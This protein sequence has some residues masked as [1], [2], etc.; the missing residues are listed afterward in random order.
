M[1]IQTHDL[2]EKQKSSRSFVRSGSSSSSG[3]LSAPNTNTSSTTPSPTATSTANERDAELDGEDDDGEG[4]PKTPLPPSSTGKKRRRRKAN[5]IDRKF[6]CS[7]PGCAK[8]YGSEGSLT[9]HQRLKHRVDLANSSNQTG[10]FFLPLHRPRNATTGAPTTNHNMYRQGPGMSRTV[11]IRPALDGMMIA[12]FDVSVA[13]AVAASGSTPAPSVSGPISTP[14]TSTSVASSLHIDNVSTEFVLA[15]VDAHSQARQKLRVRSNSMPISSSDL[16]KVEHPPFPNRSKGS[17]M[18]PRPQSTRRTRVTTT[19][20]PRTTTAAMASAKLMKQRSKSESLTEIS[21][22][23]V[24]IGTSQPHQLMRLSFLDRV[25]SDSSP[26]SYASE[27]LDTKGVLAS[28]AFDWTSLDLHGPAR[29]SSSDEVIDSEIL[30]VLAGYD[31]GTMLN[32]DGI[33]ENVRSGDG[34]QSSAVFP[35]VEV[36]GILSSESLDGHLGQHAGVG[37]TPP[38]SATMAQ[39]GEPKMSPHGGPGSVAGEENTT[40]FMRLSDEWQHLSTHLEKMT[41][42]QEPDSLITTAPFTS[43]VM[44]PFQLEIMSDDDDENFH[45]IRSK[46]GMY[47]PIYPQTMS[48]SLSNALTDDSS[49]SSVWT[50]ELSSNELD[51]SLY[52]DDDLDLT[53]FAALKSESKS[54]PRPLSPMYSFAVRDT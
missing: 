25:Y 19:P 33:L 2:P 37:M 29:G 35:T 26:R 18:T 30:S 15:S 31:D 6:A 22:G 50:K 44:D 41:M 32:G 36:N 14:P 45:T 1:R 53:T 23:L 8:A 20:R 47:L 3:T 7:Y 27:P 9:Q 5:Q 48:R 39:R 40:D 46:R 38:V 11:N 21:M 16:T 51:A 12:P 52:L 42:L 34:F 43:N 54:L 28:T 49:R 17:S 24:G 4:S 13:A 10:N